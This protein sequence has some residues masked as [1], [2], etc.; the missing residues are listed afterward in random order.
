MQGRASSR[1]PEGDE[2]VIDV[3]QTYTQPGKELYRH[4]SRVRRVQFCYSSTVA[5]GS[6][7]RHQMPASHPRTPHNTFK[8]VDSMP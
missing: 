3:S 5:V 7:L 8:Q 1:P 6:C 4:V 2:D